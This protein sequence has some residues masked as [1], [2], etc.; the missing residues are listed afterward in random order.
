MYLVLKKKI[1]LI[2]LIVFKEVTLNAPSIEE[3]S[4]SNKV[5]DHSI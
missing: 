5:N 3:K 4:M 2:Q 1:Y